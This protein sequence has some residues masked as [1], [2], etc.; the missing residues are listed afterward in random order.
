MADLIDFVPD[1]KYFQLIATVSLIC[2][3]VYFNLFERKSLHKAYLDY[4]INARIIIV[5]HEHNHSL[6]RRK[7][8][9]VGYMF[10]G[11]YAPRACRMY[12]I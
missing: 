8:D 3:V 9:S 4:Q 6:I 12:V 2:I 5:G 7:I 1:G 10:C 11:L